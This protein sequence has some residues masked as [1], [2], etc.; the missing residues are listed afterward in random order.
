MFD[1]YYSFGGLGQFTPRDFNRIF[2]YPS[3]P[4]YAIYKTMYE[5]SPI[6]RALIQCLTS[7]WHPSPRV[8]ANEDEAWEDDFDRVAKELRLWQVAK[9]VNQQAL[10]GRYAVLNMHQLPSEMDADPIGVIVGL[11]ALSE[12]YIKPILSNDGLS[13]GCIDCY[14]AGRAYSRICKDRCIH[15][16]YGCIDGEC[17]WIACVADCFE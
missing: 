6:G 14:S 1:S 15:V 17:I 8:I 16:A 3:Y 10:L 9:Q 11:S 12:R 5:T 13:K 2:G 7:F 4:S